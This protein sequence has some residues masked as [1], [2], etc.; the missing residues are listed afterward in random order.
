MMR[1]VL[2]ILHAS[3]S[4]SG[5]RATYI[6]HNDN[7]KSETSIFNQNFEILVKNPMVVF[8]LLFCIILNVFSVNLLIWLQISVS[9]FLFFLE[10]NSL[11][12]RPY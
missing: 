8:L 7:L 3:I 12:K 11:K 4:K 1:L 9:S 2:S 5:E 6:C 10:V